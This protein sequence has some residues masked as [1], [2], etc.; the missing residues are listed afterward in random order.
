MLNACKNKMDITFS[1][2]SG[3]QIS[4]HYRDEVPSSTKCSTSNLPGWAEN[5]PTAGRKGNFKQFSFR[6][7]LSVRCCRC[8]KAGSCSLVM[9]IPALGQRP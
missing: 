1:F 9:P 6:K 7:T 2:V 5:G 3:E 8:P 4:Y